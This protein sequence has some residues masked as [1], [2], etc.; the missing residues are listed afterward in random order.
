MKLV[1]HIATLFGSYDLDK[2]QKTCLAHAPTE[3]AIDLQTGL[4]TFTTTSIEWTPEMLPDYLKSLP[5]EVPLSVYGVGPN[6]LY[7]ALSVHAGQQPFY[8][9]NPKL[10]FGWVKPTYVYIGEEQSPAI[11]IK[12]ENHEECTVL[13]IAFPDDRLK[14]FQP[15]PLAFP[16][17]APEKGVILDGRLPY[18]LLA[19][20][21]RLYRDFGVPWVAPFYVRVNQAVIA[22]SRV[23]TYRLGDLVPRPIL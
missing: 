9:F 7:A 17:V 19:A 6:W 8:L 12:P 15:D 2:I 16:P 5:E 20:L 22:Y 13:K 21:M 10:P 1:G 18:W 23:E 11:R 14:Y 3:L 4:Q